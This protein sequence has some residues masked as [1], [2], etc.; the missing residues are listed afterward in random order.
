MEPVIARS[1]RRHGIS[2]AMLHAYRNPIRIVD[3]EGLIIVVGG[4]ETGRLPEV[5]VKLA[6]DGPPVIVH[7]MPARPKFLQ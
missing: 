4:D 7:A 6:V 1:A 3:D 2:E 5:D